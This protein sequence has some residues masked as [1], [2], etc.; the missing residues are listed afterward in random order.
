M[1]SRVFVQEGIADQF[2]E[3]LKTAFEAFSKGESIGDPSKETT[4]VGPIADKTQFKRVMEFMDIGK[5][6]GELVTG[7]IQRGSSGLYVEPTI[8][9]N[10]P[11]TSRIVQEEVFGPVVT[12]QTFKT[13][14]E[15]V[16]MANS[17]VF[18]LSG[19]STT[20]FRSLIPCSD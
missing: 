5:K 4:A 13:E 10:A 19:M 8:F 9:K 2:I 16:E 11:S 15:G 20:S 6:D 3:Q 17:T 18:G 1:A 14:E 7:G 12:V